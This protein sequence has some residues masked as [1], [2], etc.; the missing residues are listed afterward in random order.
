MEVIYLYPSPP[1][2]WHKELA[3]MMMTCSTLVDVPAPPYSLSLSVWM[4]PFV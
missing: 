3:M 2:G 4:T 1:I